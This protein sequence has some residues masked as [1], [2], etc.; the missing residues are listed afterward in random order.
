MKNGERVASLI[1]AS[2]QMDDVVDAVNKAILDL[3]NGK[4]QNGISLD[5]I[6]CALGSVV[7]KTFRGFPT[8]SGRKYQLAGFVDTLVSSVLDIRDEDCPTLAVEAK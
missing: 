3:L 8:A 2:N 5:V 4:Y 1:E 6:Q 7:T